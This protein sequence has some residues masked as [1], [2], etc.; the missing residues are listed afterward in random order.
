MPIFKCILCCVKTSSGSYYY[1]KHVVYSYNIRD[2]S[3]KVSFKKKN[4][5]GC[6]LPRVNIQKPYAPKFGQGKTK[7]VSGFF[8]KIVY[9]FYPFKVS[10]LYYG[11]QSAV[12]TLLKR[13]ALAVLRS[14]TRDKM[15]NRPGR[16]D[17]CV[18]PG[19]MVSLTIINKNF[20]S[21]LV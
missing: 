8:T 10:T 6:A 13:S 7:P 9:K 16:R 11:L 18:K 20:E 15:P 2:L 4:R 3:N 17:Q 14:R 21:R 19:R 5:D 1:V 12:C